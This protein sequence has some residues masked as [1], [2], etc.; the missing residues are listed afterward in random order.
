MIKLARQTHHSLCRIHL[1]L[2]LVF[3][4]LIF[5][6]ASSAAAEGTPG[7]ITDLQIQRA[8]TD[9]T[10]TWTHRDATMEHYEVW[11]SDSPYAV[12]GSAGMAK[13]ID[14]RPGALGAKVT[15]TDHF[16]TIGD[17][18]SQRLLRRAWGRYRWT[19]ISPLQSRR[20]V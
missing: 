2:P 6:Y 20:R 15:Y 17:A 16:G 14:I 10:L 19:A 18:C 8:G 1:L 12:P 11:R 5:A 9:A 3:F 4:A 13:V 7:P